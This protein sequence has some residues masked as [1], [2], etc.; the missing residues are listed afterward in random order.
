MSHQDAAMRVLCAV[1]AFVQA[2][3]QKQQEQNHEFKGLGVHAV[4]SN[5]DLP[6]PPA[7]LDETTL[8]ALVENLS[9]ALERIKEA[10]SKSAG[11]NE[12]D[13]IEDTMPISSGGG[14]A[15]GGPDEDDEEE[16]PLTSPAVLALVRKFREDLQKQQGSK[17]VRR[18]QLVAKKLAE[19]LPRIRQSIRQEQEQQRALP[20][21]P[22]PP[23]G[24]LNPPPPPPP[25]SDGLPP[26]P[27]HMVGVTTGSFDRGVSNLPA[28][29][30]R[31]SATEQVAAVEV[32]A[33]GDGTPP[34]KKIKE[35]QYPAVPESSHESLRA[36][37]SSEIQKHLGEEEETL[38]DFVF[39][40]VLDQKSVKALAMELPL[41]E[42]AAPFAAALYDKSVE[43]SSL[44]S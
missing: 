5:P 27:P 40:Y 1:R 19:T 26:P 41:E 34:S 12:D 43:L 8:Q 36:W 7:M 24:L 38:I 6:L 17:A 37:I 18:Q 30:T 35:E 33:E 32:A 42:D 22:P 20:P 31:G 44:S 16:D 3:K 39:R 14:D 25:P 29:M 10:Q 15:D 28:W 9:V 13:N 21:P 11:N 2:E 23:P 4:P